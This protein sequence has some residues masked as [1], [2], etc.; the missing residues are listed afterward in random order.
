MGP[1]RSG[2]SFERRIAWLVDTLLKSGEQMAQPGS[3]RGWEVDSV[4]QGLYRMDMSLRRRPDASLRRIVT[5]VLAARAAFE[6]TGAAGDAPIDVD[7]DG[8]ILD[9]ED[10]ADDDE[11]ATDSELKLMTVK[12]SN[13]L[14]RSIAS[15]YSKVKSA[16]PPAT[17]CSTSSLEAS[18]VRLPEHSNR[19]PTKVPSPRIT[20]RAISP[21]VHDSQDSVSALAL[22]HVP[23]PPTPVTASVEK[24]VKE[25]R[26]VGA[27]GEAP[28]SKKQR[29]VGDDPHT[30]SNSSSFPSPEW[31]VP[32]THLRDVGGVEHLLEDLVHLILLPFRHGEVHAHLGVK[33]PRGVLLHGPSGCGKTLL[34]HA[35]AGELALPLLHLSCP[36]IISSLSGD[37]EKRLREVFA[38]AR[39]VAPC[40]VF[41]DEID[42]IGTKRDQASREMERRVVAQ[43][44]TCLDDLS[45]EKSSKPV[46]VI[47]ATNRPDSLDP[48][49]RRAGRFDREIAIGVP[50][51]GAR[52]RILRVVCSKLRLTG[53]FDVFQLAKVTPGYVG[54]DLGALA[55]EA[56]LVAVRRVYEELLDVGAEPV[57]DDMEEDDTLEINGSTM[58]HD[59]DLLHRFLRSRATPLSAE[60]LEPLAITN[61]DFLAALKKVQPSSKREGFA[62]VPDVTWDDIGALTSIREELRMAVVEPIRHPEVFL[63]VGIESPMGVLLYGPP[64]CGKTLLAKAVANES[65]SNFISVKGPELLNK[66][67]GESERAIRQVFARARASAPCVVFF[68]ELDALAPT[69]STESENQSG[70]RLVNTLLTE[71][72]GLESRRSVFVIGATN[73]PDMIDPALIRPGRLDRLLYVDLPSPEERLEI[74]KTVSR[75]TPL[76]DDVNLAEVA[77]DKRCDGFSGADLTSLV[78]EAA[79]CSLR[80]THFRA[81]FYVAR[82]PSTPPARPVVTRINFDQ[83]FTKV[84]PSVSKKDY[85][86]YQSMGKRLSGIRSRLSP[87]EVPNDGTNESKEGAKEGA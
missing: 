82:D 22:N 23:P 60:E 39:Q 14:N 2:G 70:A 72:D 86:S 84:H 25:R 21:R 79:M 66:Y 58:Q 7:G 74:L 37:S 32:T 57:R 68:D 44:L 54:A 62:T 45:V 16:T 73:R 78:R 67:V 38:E 85:R 26:K 69:R 59:S 80:A 31:R 40:V 87:P 55:A 65:H 1:K 43:L 81:G 10:S 5:D 49:L 77:A 56:G 71:L 63:M 30:E 52:Q 50:D 61:A 76:G 28:P 27:V 19:Q 35:I 17:D 15:M 9:G 75:R 83:A 20:S 33:P 3:R 47:G 24:R 6:A 42:V 29:T 13:F 41:L 18:L 11:L 46:L 34:A 12:D 48:S 64:G 4:I 53:D 8:E 51:E 36:S